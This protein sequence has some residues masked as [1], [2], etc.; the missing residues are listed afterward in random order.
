[1]QTVQQIRPRFVNFVAAFKGL[2]DAGWWP[3][4]P[5]AITPETRAVDEAT[6]KRMQCPRCK[7]RGLAYR[8]FVRDGRYKVLA[9]CQ[10]EGCGAVEEV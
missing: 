10:R 3:G 8:P 7:R 4:I 2:I 5:D 1:M 6:C 9:V